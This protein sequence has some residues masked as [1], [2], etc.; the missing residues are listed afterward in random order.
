MIIRP[1]DRL[2]KL[3]EYY[4]SKKLQEIRQLNNKGHDILNL[5]IGS[6]DMM[7]SESTI[8]ALVNAARNP[9][10]H[11]Y[12][13]YRGIADL[14]DAIAHWY[15]EIYRVDLNPDHEI[16]PLMGS[17]EGITHISLAFLNPG[18]KVLVPELGYPAY[19]AVSEMVGGVVET[20]PLKENDF[21][22]PDFEYLEKADL[23]GVKILWINYPHMPTGAPARAEIFDRIV[24]IAKERKFLV[25]HDNPYSL[26]LNDG[27]PLSLLHTEGAFEVSLELNSMSKS[28]NMAGWRVGWIGGNREYINE[29]VKIKS[30]FD[31]GMFRGIQEAAVVALEN[32]REWHS[33]RNEAYRLRR[34]LVHELLYNL[35]CTWEQGQVGMFLWAR[36]PGSVEDVEKWVDRILYEHKVFITPGFVFGE[37][38]SRFVRISLCSSQTVYRKALE[39]LKDFKT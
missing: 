14:R 24:R 8:D 7:P 5:G 28:H 22:S 30:N 11:G 27:P 10:N 18:D 35:G 6:P 4:F 20:Y 16:L 26:V 15:S 31:S 39:R 21:W 33:Q 25:C 13:P 17:K 23:P 1:A 3:E 19:R 9:H 36:I 2:N 34:E 29:I 37:K 38:G 12:Q 32:P